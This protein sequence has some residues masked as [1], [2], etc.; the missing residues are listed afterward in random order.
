MLH[1]CFEREVEQQIESEVSSS[2]TDVGLLVGHVVLEF[3][4][5]YQTRDAQHSPPFG[6]SLRSSFLSIQVLVILHVVPSNISDPR[7]QQ[8]F[9]D[10]KKK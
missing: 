9:H 8:P 2:S 1:R 10:Q 4:W 7:S 3:N 6:L 5:S